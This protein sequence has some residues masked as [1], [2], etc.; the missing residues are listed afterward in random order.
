[1]HEPQ[2]FNFNCADKHK[3]RCCL[4][5]KKP[6]KT[7]TTL[8]L[9][10]LQKGFP[11][12]KIVVST[13]MAILSVLV[14]LLIVACNF[15]FG[16][17]KAPLAETGNTDAFVKAVSEKIQNNIDGN[18]VFV[19]MNNGQVASEF[20]FSK[21]EPVDRTTLFQQASVSKWVTAWGVLRL[22]EKGEIDLDKPVS[23]YLTRWSLPEGPYND[24]VTVRLILQHAAGF[25]DGLG[26]MGFDDMEQV[27]TLEDS[28][29][30]AKDAFSEHKGMTSAV[31][32]PGT[33]FNYSGGGYSL[34]QL[35]IEEVSGE[36]FSDYMSEE[37]FKP[38]GMLSATFE[39]SH[40]DKRL[41]QTF[42]EKGELAK[43]F[44]YTAK[45]AASLYAS[46]DDL[47]AF[48]KAHTNALNNSQHN[49]VLLNEDSVRIMQMDF[50]SF[51][52]KATYGTGAALYGQDDNGA[53]IM[54][55]DGGNRPDINTTA[56]V[57]PTT[58][59]GIVVLSSGANGI[60]SKI[61]SEWVFWKFGVV[62]IQAAVMPVSQNIKKIGVFALGVFVVSFIICFRRF[63]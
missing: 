1:M 11:M 57:N 2:C 63:S 34:L 5:V 47:I 9:I 25:D 4:L 42:D 62:D 12:K 51:L 61:G 46:A 26:Y 52:G 16:W 6:V 10:S 33:D 45:A 31:T 41:A 36:S 53:W 59:D 21:G 48:L 3:T 23:G 35:L 43:H 60:A 30:K 22:A 24:E 20:A 8:M 49:A 40:D 15:Y 58:G 56:R 38:L 19:L 14:V 7:S 18:A 54:G 32:K 28:L 44:Y 13:L 27:Q 50:G 17:L 39:L 37:V 29:T 55:H